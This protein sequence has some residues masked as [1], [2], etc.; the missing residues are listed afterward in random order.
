[1]AYSMVSY[2][3]NLSTENYLMNAARGSAISQGISLQIPLSRWPIYIGTFRLPVDLQK[4]LGLKY[5]KLHLR[6]AVA[7]MWAKLAIK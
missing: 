4:M 1:M 2:T 6:I 5:S 7:S 3:S